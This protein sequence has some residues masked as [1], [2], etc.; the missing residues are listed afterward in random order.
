MSAC[1][2]YLRDYVWSLFDIGKKIKRLLCA[3]TYGGLAFS[4]FVRMYKWIVNISF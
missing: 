1:M 3:D 4:V 2:Q